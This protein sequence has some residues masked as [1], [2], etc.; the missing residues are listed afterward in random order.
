MSKEGRCSGSG[1]PVHRAG[2]C[3]RSCSRL[4]PDG[5][6]PSHNEVPQGPPNLLMRLVGQDPN[7][8]GECRRA[9]TYYDPLF[10]QVCGISQDE[11]LSVLKPGK[12]WGKLRCCVPHPTP[13]QVLCLQEG[14]TN[15]PDLYFKRCLILP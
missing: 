2:L 7:L 10:T 15:T 3:A 14:P 6:C 4:I 8:N 5:S 12:V 11:R 13:G 9:L 1:L